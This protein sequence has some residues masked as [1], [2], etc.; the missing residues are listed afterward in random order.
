MAVGG[1][2]TWAG[3]GRRVGL[4]LAAVSAARLLPYAAWVAHRP[5]ASVGAELGVVGAILLGWPIGVGVANWRTGWTPLSRAVAVAATLLAI[6]RT[7][8]LMAGI[9]LGGATVGPRGGMPWLR[10]RWALAAC[11]LLWVVEVVVAIYAWR[12]VRG[13][14]ADGNGPRWRSGS[15]QVLAVGIGVFSALWL[16]W[17]TA[18]DAYHALLHLPRVRQYVLR[19]DGRAPGRIT[20]PVELPPLAREGLD[21]FQRATSQAFG[22]RYAEAKATYLAAIDAFGRL[23]RTSKPQADY[24]LRLGTARNNLAWLLTTCP[25]PSIR[26]PAGAVALAGRAVAA[27]PEDG[28]FWNTLGAAQYRAD[29]PD[30][31]E[32]SLGRSMAL[33]R[34]G[35]GFD[36]YFL[37]LIHARRGE[38]AEARRELERADRWAARNQPND[39]ELHR[40]SAEA[41]GALELPPARTEDIEAGFSGFREDSGRGGR[42]R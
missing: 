32:R 22:G 30:A 37:S 41:A 40:F 36:W 2:G 7:V 9:A 15:R 11:A 5:V 18:W 35:D 26:D 19:I 17:L 31:A 14:S 33:R 21:A 42:R 27:S 4:A 38:L 3:R 24:K 25:D 13:V 6:D 34:G 8:L 29:D 12:V 28:S 20:N 23:E 1:S 10:G 16:G 39:T